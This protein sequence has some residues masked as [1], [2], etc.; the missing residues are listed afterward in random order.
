[1]RLGG[2]RRTSIELP[3]IYVLL[4]LLL[5][6]TCSQ[7]NDDCLGELKLDKQ[8]M[9][10]RINLLRA[11]HFTTRASKP[12][13]RKRA[14]FYEVTWDRRLHKAAKELVLRTM[15]N[16][17]CTLVKNEKLGPVFAD[18]YDNTSSTRYPA[19][20][21]LV[22]GGGLTKVAEAWWRAQGPY[23]GSDSLLKRP[24]LV[25]VGCFQHH[26]GL[27]RRT[28]CFYGTDPASIVRPDGSRSIRD[29]PAAG[30]MVPVE[31]ELFSRHKWLVPYKCKPKKTPA[32]ATQA[33]APPNP[34][35]PTSP[36]S[37][38][39]TPSTVTPPH[40]L[41]TPYPASYWEEL[42]KSAA[43]K[44]ADSKVIVPV[45]IVA[46]IAGIAAIGLG[47][48]VAVG[49]F[50]LNK[51]GAASVVETRCATFDYLNLVNEMGT[52]THDIYTL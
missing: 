21:V 50:L 32:P 24:D 40:H 49:H 4:L 7:G 26:V 20:H 42:Q 48:W 18:G 46:A 12:N 11:A 29:G 14:Y 6:A 15:S 33:P 8:K 1:M 5:L 31:E 27:C 19:E 41:S 28:A 45:E 52:Q 43:G 51:T 39:P 34:I 47:I 9:I 22:L 23:V 16:S 44:T 13:L 2:R 17:A 35:P 3:S 38:T 30:G 37:K 25:A 10:R 36:V